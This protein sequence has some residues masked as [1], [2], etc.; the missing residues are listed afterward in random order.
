MI[1]SL[2]VVFSIGV[3]GLTGCAS[4]QQDHSST[5]PDKTV[6]VLAAASLQQAFDDIA[7]EFAAEHPEIDIDLSYA[8]SSTL[9]HNLD[10]GAPADVLATA[11]EASMDTAEEAGLIDTTTRT[12]VA[13]NTLVGIVPADNPAGVDSLDDL[14][15]PEV[16][17]V[18]CAP[19]VPC[20][21]LAR[22]IADQAG[23]TL[24][25]VSEE[26]QVVDVVGKV[27]SGQADAGLVYATDAAGAS[28]EVRD[29]SL[30]G[31][32]E[33]PNFYPIARTVEARDRPSADAFIDFVLSDRGQAILEAHGFGLPEV[34][35]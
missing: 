17:T 4:A 28:G 15:Q 7:T 20:G 33:S 6:Q 31:A 10:A 19:Q 21:A 12:V 3:L 18:I 1:R 11:D 25:P 22:T 26:H 9:I 35:S 16:N 32:A 8:G 23:I 5:S 14:A 30:E 24:D 13:T 29:F 34:E 27:R 2:L